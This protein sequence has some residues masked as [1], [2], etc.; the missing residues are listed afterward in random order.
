[1]SS[2]AETVTRRSTDRGVSTTST[3]APPKGAASDGARL[4]VA[5]PRIAK[6]SCVVPMGSPPLVSSRA[7]VTMR[8]EEDSSTAATWLTTSIERTPSATR[9]SGGATSVIEWSRWTAL[10]R[11][12]MTG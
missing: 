10:S 11:P 1:M 5:R 12:S 6:R 9:R 7:T 2:G 8:P 3:E 4:P